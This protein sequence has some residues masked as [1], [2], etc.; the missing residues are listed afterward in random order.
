MKVLRAPANLRAEVTARKRAGA[1][2][3]FAPTMGALHDGHL[4]LIRA[5]RA[6]TDVVVVSIFV[7]P[8]QFGA[9]EDFETY[10]RDETAD[11]K[12]LESEGVDLVFLPAVEDMYPSDRSTSIEVG[13]LGSILEG[14]SRPGHFSGVATVVAK[15]F[16]IVQPDVAFFGQK[17][18]QQLAVVRRIA[19]DL[20][21]PV[22]IRSCPTIRES[23]GLAMSSRNVRLDPAERARATAL[24]AALEAGAR[25]LREEHNAAAAEK[26]MLETLHAA[27]IDPDYAVAV[28]P[29]TFRP[30]AEAAPALL[31]IAARIGGTRLIDNLLVN[32]STTSLEG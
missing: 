6:A 20:S 7:N 26:T 21:F 12:L 17:D 5:A 8:L 30:P 14:A 10:P 13:E 23:D 11:L 16:N 28:D 3:G 31:A 9:D 4:S 19:A 27:G 24:F 18:A 29:T 2:V 32:D 22:E 25:V 15:L 1:T